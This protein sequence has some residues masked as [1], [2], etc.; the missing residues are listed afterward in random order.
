MPTARTLKALTFVPV[1]WDSLETAERAKVKSGKD[2]GDTGIGVSKRLNSVKRL[3]TMPDFSHRTAFL[4]TPP[5]PPSPPPP[6][7]KQA[8]PG[9]NL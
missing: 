8:Q 1:T 4:F 9:V 5:P 3:M 2:K 7:K 6:Q